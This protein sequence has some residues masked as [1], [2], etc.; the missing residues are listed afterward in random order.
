MVNEFTTAIDATTNV[1]QKCQLIINDNN[2]YNIHNIDDQNIKHF[3][4]SLPTLKDEDKLNK[5]NK[6]IKQLK[7][8]KI[9]NE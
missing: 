4:N 7:I 8:L 6:V 9:F 3:F 5:Y 2:N 1:I